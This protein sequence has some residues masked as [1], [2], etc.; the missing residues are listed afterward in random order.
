MGSKRTS[1]EERGGARVE[2]LAPGTALL[3]GMA[4]GMIRFLLGAVLAG[5]EVLGMGAPFGVGLTACSGSGRDGLCAVTGACLGYLLFHPPASGLRYAAACVLVFSVAFAFYDIKLYKKAWFMP[6]TAALMDGATGFVYL[7]ESDWG[8]GQVVLFLCEMTVAGASAY[9]YRV[10]LTPRRSGGA[11]LTTRQTVS[12]LFLLGSLLMSL[13]GITFFEDLSLGRVLAVLLVMSLAR[14]GG[15]TVGAAAGVAV[16]LGMDLCAGGGGFY[17]MAYGFAGLLT[18]A[19][20]RQGRLFGAITYVM[21]NA[22][23][24]LWAWGDPPRFSA[25]YEAFIASVFFLLIPQ[26]YL[27][28]LEELFRREDGGLARMGEACASQRLAGA[29]KAF[30]EVRDSL[31]AS[32]PQVGP[33]DGDPAKVFDRAAQKVCADCPLQGGCWQRD[34]VST[35]SALNDALPAMMDRG[36][37][38]AADFPGWFSARCVRFPRF[39]QAANEELVAL[40]YRRQYQSRLRENRGAVCRQYETL[41]DILSAAATE[42]SAELTP[43][44]VRERRLRQYLADRGLEGE[45]AVYYDERGRLR[46]EL[47]GDEVETLHSAEA[48]GKLSDLM[49]L[50]LR[51]GPQVPGR[52]TLIQAEPLMAVAGIA[53]RRREGQTESGDTGTWFKREDGSLFVLL[54]DGMGSGEWAHRESALAVRLLEE[55]LRSGMES[56]AALRTVSGALALRNEEAGAFT[57][58]DLLRL[59]LYTGGGEVCK[60][61]AAPTYVRRGDTVSRLT[62]AALPAGL[63]DGSPDVTPLALEPGDCVLLVSDGVADPEE[64]GWLR[65]LL[66]GF[67]GASPKEL[68]RAVMEE[69]EKRVGAA[70]DRTTVA[71]QLKKR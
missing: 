65:E 71:I 37:G 21:A 8:A 19:G 12:F 54:C 26:K 25:L 58:V 60:L 59:D 50:P 1:S 9:L 34:Y 67:D 39:L 7:S 15:L 70:D 47:E 36:K 51:Y 66:S 20:W 23:A 28:R 30:R 44:P 16:G 45:T 42:L 52:V 18:G 63:A 49:G 55:F 5:G 2:R 68:A 43:D 14:A 48:Q 61:G 4:E 40:R 29:A 38:E 24:V 27:R 62:G 57:T 11:A 56:Q 69:S 17:A 35:Y 41:A 64:D 3:T 10:A 13:A 46:L 32:F 33:N 6:L 22:V 31:R 53:A